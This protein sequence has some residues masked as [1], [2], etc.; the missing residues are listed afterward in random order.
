MAC[1]AVFRWQAIF[2][3]APARAMQRAQLPARKRLR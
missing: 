3:P 1:R 2:H